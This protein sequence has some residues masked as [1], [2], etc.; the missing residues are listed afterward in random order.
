MSYWRERAASAIEQ[1]I[2]TINVNLEN[3][4]EQDK[5]QLKCVIDA[6]Y[7]FR[8]RKNHPYQIW[9]DERQKAFERLGIIN[10]RLRR[11]STA[12]SIA[13]ARDLTVPGQQS[14]F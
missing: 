11:K 1:A 10:E 3:L 14:L 5:Q 7:P 2:S 12:S 4:S 8:T 9:L 13:I 6:A